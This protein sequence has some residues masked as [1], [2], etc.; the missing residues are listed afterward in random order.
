MWFVTS[1]ILKL[2]LGFAVLSAPLAFSEMEHVSHKQS[3]V[4]TRLFEA[5]NDIDKAS[6]DN[7]V[8]KS[9]NCTLYGMRSRMQVE[10]NLKLYAFNQE[11]STL[12]NQGVQV[13]Q[14]YKLES[15]QLKGINGS[16]E[17]H[18]RI[19]NKGEIITRL[20][21]LKKPK[22]SVVAYATCRSI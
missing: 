3:E 6:V 16:L 15:K 1:K 9:W 17:D 11:G 22:P 8:N 19:N 13:I 14:K 10:R 18:V 2:W 12:K 20:S 7:L 21:L 5:A 4:L